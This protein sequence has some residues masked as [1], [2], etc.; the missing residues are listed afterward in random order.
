MAV[1][2]AGTSLPVELCEIVMNRGER[3]RVLR[4]LAMHFT[5][6]LCKLLHFRGWSPLVTIRCK[7]EYFACCGRTAP[8]AIAAARRLRDGIEPGLRAQHHG[9]IDID[10]RFNQ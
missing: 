4:V 6:D 10:A 8:L 1:Q 2:F 9:E 7:D 3:E 5:K